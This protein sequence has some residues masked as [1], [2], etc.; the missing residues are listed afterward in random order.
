MMKGRYSMKYCITTI[1][2]LFAI[3][4]SIIFLT[5][6]YAVE[7]FPELRWGHVAYSINYGHSFLSFKVNNSMVNE[8]LKSQIYDS[9]K[10]WT[11]NSENYVSA[12]ISGFD[13]SNIDFV[14]KSDWPCEWGSLTVASTLLYDSYGNMFKNDGLFKSDLK[15]D[16]AQVFIN[17]SAKDLPPDITELAVRRSLGHICCFG[18]PAKYTVSIMNP[19]NQ[20]Y[21]VPQPY[22]IG[23]LKKLYQ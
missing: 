11:D 18:F 2:L 8:T 4:S 3:L 17:P 20:D 6:A 5:P 21:T 19:F 12:H 15:V 10:V 14:E 22:D 16:Y 23:E 1:A 13:N 7:Y 9:C